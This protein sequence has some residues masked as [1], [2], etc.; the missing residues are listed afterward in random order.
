MR[1]SAE[2]RA[3][4]G[5]RPVRRAR[6]AVPFRR[7]AWALACLA[8]LGCRSRSRLAPHGPSGIT[9][10]WAW[11][12]RPSTVS[13]L[14]G[15]LSGQHWAGAAEVLHETLALRAD[16][17]HVTH[18][19]LARTVLDSGG[20]PISA[21]VPIPGVPATVDS[22]RWRYEPSGPASGTL[23]R[24]HRGVSGWY[25]ARTSLRGDTLLLGLGG[26]AQAYLRVERKPGADAAS[27]R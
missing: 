20:R 18:S 13:H 2:R 12:S 16:G 9:G 25:C 27:V 19:V 15:L 3:M 5:S 23:C 7:F 26:D 17:R 6:A 21:L 10:R 14:R 8:I 11:T 22:G 4:R 24:T 1:V